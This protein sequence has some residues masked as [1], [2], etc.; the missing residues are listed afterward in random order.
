M[1]QALVLSACW[2]LSVGQKLTRQKT[3]W[4]K[5]S[6]DKIV[7]DKSSMDESSLDK[8][9]PDKSSPKS[10]IADKSSLQ[11]LGS[12]ILISLQPQDKPQT[13]WDRVSKLT[14]TKLSKSA[15]WYLKIYHVERA[16]KLS[17]GRLALDK[18]VCSWHTPNFQSLPAGTW[19]SIMQVGKLSH[20]RLALD[21]LSL[22]LAE[23]E[24]GERKSS[25]RT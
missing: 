16:G 6:L 13:H 17:H 11:T 3:Q 21:K 10:G 5:S 19:K 9:S 15:G 14:H 18:L 12:R 1:I 20:G 2:I 4:T 25:T 7:P 24:R 23:R 22:Q 8:S